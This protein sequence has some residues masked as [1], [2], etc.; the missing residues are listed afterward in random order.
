MEEEQLCRIKQKF[1]Q[2][3]QQKQPLWLIMVSTLSCVYL[4][5][6][7][8]GYKQCPGFHI[9][10]SLKRPI[11]TACLSPEQIYPSPEAPCSL[12]SEYLQPSHKAQSG[13]PTGGA[14]LTRRH[15]TRQALFPGGGEGQPERTALPTSSPP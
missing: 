5:A 11:Q 7:T 13:A 14:D 2:N 12:P 3:M 15:E 4:H 1:P 9:K 10:S 6:V 8:Y